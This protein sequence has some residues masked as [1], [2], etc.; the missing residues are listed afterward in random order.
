[1]PRVK[2]TKR[3]AIPDLSDL[4]VKPQWW[5]DLH[6]PIEIIGYKMPFGIQCKVEHE[7]VQ[8]EGMLLP[9]EKEQKA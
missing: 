8:Y 9:V 1:M 7:G 4:K 2:R 5:L 6:K 3:T